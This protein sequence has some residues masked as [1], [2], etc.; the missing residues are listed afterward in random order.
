MRSGGNYLFSEGLLDGV[1]IIIH[2]QGSEAE[3][4]DMK[5]FLGIDLA[6][7]PTFQA[8]NKAHSLVL[9]GIMMDQIYGGRPKRKA[10]SQIRRGLLEA[11]SYLSRF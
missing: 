10:S 2:L 8:L 7:L 1:I 6:A 11:L 9:L 4:A 5:G 3:A